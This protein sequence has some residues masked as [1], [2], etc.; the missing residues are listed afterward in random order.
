M[1]QKSESSIPLARSDRRRQG[2]SL[3]MRSERTKGGLA[4]AATFL[5]WGI[6]PIYWKE[7]DGVPPLEVVAHRLMW[8]S[9]LLVTLLALTGRL[10]IYRTEFS[11]ASQVLS[12]V[13]RAF[14]LAVNWLVYIW[15]VSHDRILEAS[16]GYFLVPVV[17]VILG[18]VFLKE[19]LNARC[20]QDRL[21]TNCIWL[22][23]RLD[24]CRL[25]HE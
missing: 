8:T 4:A 18:M 25:R 23:Y 3:Y 9:I 11:S 1:L 24:L 20:D 2:V 6:L 17:N 22:H 7:L 5:L 15:A 21:S 10:R 19:R 13:M 14:L 12:H 16:L